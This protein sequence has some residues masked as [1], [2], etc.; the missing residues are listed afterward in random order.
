MHAW[1]QDIAGHCW[2]VHAKVHTFALVKLPYRAIE[3]CTMQS[4]ELLDVVFDSS[5]NVRQNLTR[6]ATEH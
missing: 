4:L 3:Y 5:V 6:C 2:T 1:E